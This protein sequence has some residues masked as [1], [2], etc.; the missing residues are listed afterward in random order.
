M[1]RPMRRLL[2]WS[3]AALLGVY[4]L[5]LAAPP[6]RA[7]FFDESLEQD[8][9]FVEDN[10]AFFEDTSTDTTGGEPSTGTGT[11]QEPDFTEGNRFVDEQLVPGDRRA[12][13]AGGRRMQLS[14]GRDREVLPLNVAWGA[15]TGLV[16]GGWYALISEGDNRATQRTIGMSIVVGILLG[17]AIG[18]RTLFDPNAPRPVGVGDAS[19]GPDTGHHF[20]PVVAADGGQSRVGFRLTF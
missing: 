6:A 8:E 17:A 7:Q 15:G 18:T 10:N 12:V 1:S 20:T 11:G 9:L 5:A 2:S 19:P 16:I 13:S 4:L 14:L 3:F